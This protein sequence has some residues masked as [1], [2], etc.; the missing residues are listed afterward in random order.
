MLYLKL[1]RVLMIMRL[2]LIGS[3]CLLC[4]KVWCGFLVFLMIREFGKRWRFLKIIV[5]VN[6]RCCSS[7]GF[8]IVV[9][10]IILKLVFNKVLILVWILVLIFGVLL[11]SI[12]IYYNIGISFKFKG[13][14]VGFISFYI[15]S[16]V[17]CLGF[18]CKEVLNIVFC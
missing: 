18:I 14:V 10:E 17:G 11:S 12:I 8:L 5:F 16:I 6:G 13:S 3:W 9:L 1:E 15:E 7:L 2:L 4:F